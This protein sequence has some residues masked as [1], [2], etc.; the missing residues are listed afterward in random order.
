[1]KPAEAEKLLGGYATGTLTEA[2]R[3]SLFAAALGHQA[4]FDALMGE[5]ALRELLADPMAK[6]QLLAALAPAPPKV[7]PFWGRP[8][9]LGAAAGLIVA[10]TAGLAYL[11]SP[12]AVPPPVKQEAAKAPAS[13]SIAMPAEATAPAAP[14]R[15]AAQVSQ[16]VAPSVAPL[17]EVAAPAQPAEAMPPPPVPAPQ[18]A[19]AAGAPASAVEDSARMRTQADFRR[20]EAQD[21]L[22]KK[23]EAPRPAAAVVE[24]VT[25]QKADLSE[26][27]AVAQGHLAESVPGAVAGGVLAGSPPSAAAKAKASRGVGMAAATAPIA[28]AWTLE[29]QPDGTTRMTVKA[30]RG[31]Q[32][33]LLRRGSAG[34]EVLRLQVLEDR[35]NALVQ[36]RGEVRLAPGDVLD[37][38][39]LNHAVADPFK[40]PETGPV[41]GF[42]AR[43][44]PAVKKDPAR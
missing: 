44:H 39:L 41:D 21:N 25:T 12:E 27:R 24:V 42:R 43:I 35:G 20:A 29:T 23:A 17:K 6:A 5:E 26:P 4:I 2:E 22:A 31:Q 14:M 30:P 40:L 11:R 37:L 8:T 1:V 19:V 15:K 10:A 16:L 32:V 38:Y 13:K 28:P 9:L 18:M 33:A 3:K 36:W 7:I 34:I